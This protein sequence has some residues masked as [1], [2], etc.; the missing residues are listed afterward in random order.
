MRAK[1]IHE[2]AVVDAN[3]RFLGLVSQ[4]VLLRRHKL[5]LQTRVT[6]VAINPPRLSMD[7]PLP[8]AAKALLENGFREL[9]VFDGKGQVPAGQVSRRRL[10]DLLRK[11]REIAMLA[12]AG[13]MT[14]DPV[15]AQ[16]EDTV[17]DALDHMRKLDEPTLPVVDKLGKLTGVIAASDIMRVYAGLTA[18]AKRAQGG[19]GNAKRARVT[20]KG[21]MR[22]PAVETRRST[23][24]GELIDLM[25]ESGT[26]SVVVVEGERPVGI[27]TQADLLSLVAS[28]EPREGCFIQITGLERHDPFFM[29]EV[30]DVV[31]PAVMKMATQLR[32]LAL[33]LHVMEHHRPNGHRVECRARLNTDRGL[34]VATNEDDD[35]MRAVAGL[36]DRLEKIA[37]R[38]KDRSRLNP[39]KARA[40]VQPAGRA[41]VV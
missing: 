33:H 28:L 17:G 4:E 20:V 32:P 11:D 24:V 2:I 12:A 14:P 18:P 8:R 29:E 23:S 37:T 35:V 10:L 9:P 41:K 15:L 7:D 22:S 39:N 26:S 31:D 30:W 38:E 21:L 25:E 27:V 19:S 13:V 40:G 16:E 6:S 5:P 34:I 1:K 3:G 36:F